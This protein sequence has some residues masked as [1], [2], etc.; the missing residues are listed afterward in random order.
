METVPALCLRPRVAWRF[1]IA[2]FLVACASLPLAIAAEPALA[3]IFNGRDLAGWSVGG[4]ASAASNWR[5]ENGVLIG[6]SNEKLQGSNLGTE[7]NYGDFV[8]EFEG[9]WTGAEIDTG[10]I[11]RRPQ[12]QFQIGV[13]RS[14]ERDMTGSWCLPPEDAVR[15]PEA[16]QAK[17]WTQHFKSGAWNTYRIE[18]RGTTFSAW[19]NGRRVSQYSDA[20]YAE[21]APIRLQF[22]G[23]LKMKLE[24][25]NIRLAEL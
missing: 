25:R 10:V 23:G 22:H 15:Y 21:P 9:R 4:E 5:V 7:K 8:L 14:M 19:I 18:A 20:K 12:I 2:I 17:D 16:G 3:P 24:F 11:I 13:S 6:E 1:V